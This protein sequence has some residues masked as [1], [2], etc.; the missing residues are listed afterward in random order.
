MSISKVIS[1]IITIIVISA[2]KGL[3]K[4]KMKAKK[5]MSDKPQSQERIVNKSNGFN[6]AYKLWQEGNTREALTLLKSSHLHD[7]SSF[8]LLGELYYELKEF[9]LAAT[10]YKKSIRYSG[11]AF[12]YSRLG[13]IYESN[14]LYNESIKL[15]KMA[16]KFADVQKGFVYHKLGNLYMYTGFEG[17]SDRM[18]EKADSFHDDEYSIKLSYDYSKK[19]K[20]SPNY[21]SVVIVLFALLLGAGIFGLI[22]YVPVGNQVTH[23][24]SEEIVEEVIEEVIEEVVEEIENEPSTFGNSN[25]NINYGGYITEY[26]GHTYGFEGEGILKIS[27]YENT[28]ELMVPTLS[29]LYI[30]VLENQIFYIRYDDEI[31]VNYHHLKEDYSISYE[32]SGPWNLLVDDKYLYFIDEGDGYQSLRIEDYVFEN[33]SLVLPLGQ[34]SFM[35]QTE[36]HLMFLSEG[37]L[38][39]VE[40]D[41]LNTQDQIMTPENILYSD[42]IIF[43]TVEN[44]M[45]Y[46]IKEDDTHI[47]KMTFEGTDIVAILENYDYNSMTLNVYKDQLFIGVEEEGTVYTDIFT[48]EGDYV[49]TIEDIIG[50]QLSND[51]LYWYEE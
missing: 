42:Q 43:V 40:K 19:P 50:N 44:D 34:V 16:L 22:M 30:N 5:E 9:D 29:A 36:D 24:E 14:E 23:E 48:I 33:D 37:T 25:S 4:S 13:E 32:A 20:G 49:S 28:S 47:Y 11:T 39:K 7:V 1:I 51:Y 38:Y 18:L 45:I 27:E 6:E 12:A 8:I 15:F 2:S 3:F 10:A 35:N 21:A 26:D 41:S 46:F 17:L 31:S